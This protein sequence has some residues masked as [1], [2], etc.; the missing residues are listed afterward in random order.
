M[1]TTLM[2]ATLKYF[3]ALAVTAVVLVV[4]GGTV[5]HADQTECAQVQLSSGMVMQGHGPT[6]VDALLDV[7]NRAKRLGITGLPTVLPS[8]TW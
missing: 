3:G 8:C 5:A 2:K 6:P 4:G 1:K 7:L